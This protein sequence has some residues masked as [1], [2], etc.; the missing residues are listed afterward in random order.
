MVGILACCCDMVGCSGCRSADFLLY[1]F[2]SPSPFPHPGE[3]WVL[4]H[5]KSHRT[6]TLFEVYSLPPLSDCYHPLRLQLWKPWVAQREVKS[7]TH[8]S[9]HLRPEKY[10]RPSSKALNYLPTLLKCHCTYLRNHFCCPNYLC[11]P[12]FL[13]CDWIGKRRECGIFFLK[14]RKDYS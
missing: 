9:A 6:H 8:L 12:E 1:L 5:T 7:N 11:C 13:V 2:P 4:T 14:N 3:P 10:T